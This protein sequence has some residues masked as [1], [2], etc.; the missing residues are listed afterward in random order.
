MNHSPR[1]L[2]LGLDA[3]SPHLLRRWASEGVLPNIQRLFERG[4]QASTRTVEGVYVGATW[5][6]FYM[7]L[8]PG[9]HGLYWLDRVL[10]GTYRMQ[11]AGAEE[12]RQQPALWD[13]LSEAGRRCVVVDV[14]LSA[15]SPQVDGLQVL[16]WGVHDEVFGFRSQPASLAADLRDRH[17]DH[18]APS[19]CDAVRDPAEQQAFA[20]QL[21]AG[22]GTRADLL[23]DLLGRDPDW[24]FAIQVFSETHCAGHQLWHTHDAAHPAHDPTGDDLVRRVYEA[25]D[26]A[27]GRIVESVGPDTTVALIDLHGMGSSGGHSLLLEPLLR[28]LG[29]QVAQGEASG[30][31]PPPPAPTSSLA[32]P[33]SQPA[34][35][36]APPGGGLSV[37]GIVRALYRGLLP[38]AARQR[39]YA[40]RQDRNQARGLGSPLD[41]DPGR[42]KAF[43]VG[44]GTGPPFSA[45]RLNLKGREPAGLLEPGAEA[46]AFV[47]RLKAE[48]ES[49]VDP[50]TGRPCV[51]RVLR[52][53][54]VFEGA[55]VD[56]L[57]DVLVEWVIE[58]PRGTM[59]AGGG[60]GAEWIVESP[61][62]GRLSAVNRY[63][64]TGEH[65][66]DG[67]V[68]VAGPG[69][70]PGTVER[71]L[72]I[73]ELAPTFAALLGHEAPSMEKAPAP[74]FLGG[75]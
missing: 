28:R 54:D 68:V 30:P 10:L 46:D 27:I 50:R 39:I 13:V 36:T 47:E 19:H 53:R 58:P 23:I 62:V 42:T 8:G 52:S 48:L 15:L 32:E 69:I 26:A 59:A 51:A 7:G 57:P 1:L 67:L 64:R 20:G 11:R 61:S 38:E 22:A 25:V 71:T 14:P 2:V 65:R 18:P 34:P 63:C 60:E 55:R 12:M 43:Y 6:S 24:S 16:E 37:G 70:D 17:G 31:A 40:W 49:L 74:E 21:V 35:D 33:A 5:P 73:L 75:G 3:A 66:P 44:L 29:I 56:E 9:H 4:R 72:S 41:V 45:I